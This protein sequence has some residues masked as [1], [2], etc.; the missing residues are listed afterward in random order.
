MQNLKIEWLFR[1]SLEPRRL[2]KRYL[3]GGPVFLGRVAWEA[4]KRKV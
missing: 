3:L 1:M 4:I 2:W